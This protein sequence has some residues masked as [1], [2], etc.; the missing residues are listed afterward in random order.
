MNKPALPHSLDRTLPF[1]RFER[2]GKSAINFSPF[3]G[4]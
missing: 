4:P 2:H 3:K 1:W